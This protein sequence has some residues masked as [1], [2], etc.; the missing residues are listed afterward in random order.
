MGLLNFARK[1]IIVGTFQAD[2]DEFRNAAIESQISVGKKIFQDVQMI[3]SLTPSDLKIYAPSLREKYKALRNDAL[4]AGAKNALHP[5]YAYAAIMESI[6]LSIG[7]DDSAN[8][9]MKDL[10]GWLSMLG[11]IEKEKL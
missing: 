8:K 1:K 4:N 6:V 10:I 3:G 2:F 11:V 7:D 9:I 5:D